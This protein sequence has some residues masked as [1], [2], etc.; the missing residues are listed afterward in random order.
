[1]T[2]AERRA[3]IAWFVLWAAASLAIYLHINVFGGIDDEYRGFGHVWHPF[4]FNLVYAV[5]GVPPALHATRRAARRYGRSQL[6]RTVVLL[7]C[8]YVGWVLG[9][10]I[11]FWFNT[12]TTWRVFGCERAFTAPYPSVA[13][14]AYSSWLVFAL[15][16]MVALGRALG[17]R[18]S[19][20]VRGWWMLSVVAIVT[21]WLGLPKVFEV[22]S[23][24]FGQGWLVSADYD[25]L[26]TT[27][28]VA[29]LLGH[30][31]VLSA[32]LVVARRAARTL[33]GALHAPMLILVA[34][35]ALIYVAEL[36]FFRTI[37]NETFRNAQPVEGIYALALLLIPISLYRFATVALPAGASV[38][39]PDTGSAIDQLATSIVVAHARLLGSV[40]VEL[41]RRVDGVRVRP[42]D[43]IAVEVAGE[44]PTAILGEL[45]RTFEEVSGAFGIEVSRL[46]AAHVLREHPDVAVPGQLRA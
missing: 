37:A 42:G 15:L 21:C 36:A 18:R 9:N 30:V 2:R 26:E 17:I 43:A 6:G 46:A 10:V 8:G 12:C 25:A 3:Y 16:S 40:A 33:G 32:A 7:T 23:F 45:V 5:L 31:L 41:A 1:M 27:F 34:A 4:W 22:G 44:D 39:T 20:L 35:V 11:W 28:S 14:I 19:D 29:Y 38:A 24:T 13:D